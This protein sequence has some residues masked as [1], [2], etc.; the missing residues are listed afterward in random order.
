M[1]R[2]GARVPPG[3]F[4]EGVIDVF[5][6]VWNKPEATM[7]FRF[8]Q[9]RALRDFVDLLSESR[10]PA[11]ARILVVG[12]GNGFGGRGPGFAADV[13]QEFYGSNS[14]VEIVRMEI[15]PRILETCTVPNSQS[16]GFALVVTH[17]LIHYLF[18]MRPFF[19]LV[20]RLLEPGGKYLMANEPNSRFW[21]NSECLK[22]LKLKESMERRRKRALRF[23]DLRRY[24]RRIARSMAS[25]EPS[26][27]F[28]VMNRILRGR[29]GLCG[30]LTVSEILHVSDPHMP[31][32]TSPGFRLGSNGL[33]WE[34]LQPVIRPLQLECTRTSGYLGQEN[35]D[36]IDKNWR[37][38]DRRMAALYPLDG[39]SFG[40]LWR[41]PK[42]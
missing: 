40:A 25:G 21:Q 29:F 36:R 32:A 23:L 16:Q 19:T 10:L 15:T 41:K 33:D 8:R 31:D 11:E 7:R 28:A 14:L 9:G 3:E 42:V 30:D 12:C 13:V 22:T 24:W 6:E 20:N 26:D 5:H 34:D 27:S 4:I 39:C 2:V 17:S 1:E 38:V 18:D 37:D 35:L